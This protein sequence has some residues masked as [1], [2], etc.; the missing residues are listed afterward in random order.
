MGGITAVWRKK[1]RKYF[2]GKK[3]CKE[4]WDGQKTKT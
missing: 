1:R 3:R 2:A 4:P